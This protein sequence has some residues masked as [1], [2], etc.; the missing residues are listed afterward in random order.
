MLS[1]PFLSPDDFT[2]PILLK[3][4]D[5]TNKRLKFLPPSPAA[6]A[7]SHTGDPTTCS[8][9]RQLLN[10]LLA[11]MATIRSPKISPLGSL[12]CRQ[13]V[14]PASLS[15]SSPS[16]LSPPLIPIKALSYPV[17]RASREGSGL[18]PSH[19]SRSQSPSISVCAAK[20]TVRTPKLTKSC[21]FGP[22]C[23]DEEIFPSFLTKKRLFP[24]SLNFRLGEGGQN[25][26][27]CRHP[28]LPR[29]EARSFPLLTSEFYCTI[30]S[31]RTKRGG[32]SAILCSPYVR[33]L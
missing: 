10:V 33:R 15:N 32:L 14:C 23:K 1:P 3:G 21:N 7:V 31:M 13:S 17:L 18:L 20:G 30:N 25:T 11:L 8:N 27:C 16:S 2:T 5:A 12:D 22:Q 28:G 4:G 9:L 6:P 26:S 19:L 29:A 24:Y